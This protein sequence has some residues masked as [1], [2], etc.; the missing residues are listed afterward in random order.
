MEFWKWYKGVLKKLLQKL[1]H[2]LVEPCL[3]GF[4]GIMSMTVTVICVLVLITKR[5]LYSAFLASL[6]LP[7]WI[8]MIAHAYYRYDKAMTEAGYPRWKRQGV[9][10]PPG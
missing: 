8:T 3:E 9:K 5:D 10:L 1:R 2:I 4:V 7:L 6:T